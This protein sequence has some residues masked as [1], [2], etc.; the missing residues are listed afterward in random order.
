VKLRIEGS[1]LGNVRMQV[2]S[3]ER[4]CPFSVTWDSEVGFS[5]VQES[6]VA[7]KEQHHG[8]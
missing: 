1:A 5:P 7:N 8:H 3:Y 2:L 4:L 6:T